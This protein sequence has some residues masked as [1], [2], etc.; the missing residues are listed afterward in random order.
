MIDNPSSDVKVH[1]ELYKEPKQ[2][3]LFEDKTRLPTGKYH[4]SF[5]ELIIW[6]ECSWR[7]KLI[8]IDQLGSDPPNQHTEFGQALHD[9]A[10]EYVTKRKRHDYDH[11]ETIRKAHEELTRRYEVIKYEEDHTPWHTG[12]EAILRQLPEW[13]ENE[14]PGWEIVAAE[15]MLFEKIEGLKNKFFKGFIDCVIR[16]PKKPRKGSKPKSEDTPIEWEY[17][18]IDWKGT[19][20]GWSLDKKTDPLKRMQVVLYKHNLCNLLGLD[21]KQVKCGFVLCKRKGGKEK[22]H[23]ESVEVSAGPETI[24]KALETIERMIL[25]VQKKMY[26]KNKRSCTYCKFKNTKHCP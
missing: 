26:L 5:S 4:I 22:Q 11:E 10:E 6:S 15:H 23:F 18:I 19:D 12:L 8:Y 21:L 14:F 7:H 2:I 20:W 9:G 13:M 3:P 1:L 17:R 25:S 16:Y 24:K